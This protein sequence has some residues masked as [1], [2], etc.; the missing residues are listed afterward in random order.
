MKRSKLLI[1]DC[2][3]TVLDTFELIEHIVLSTFYELL[4]DYHISL[5]EAH[6]FFG[7]YINDTFKKYEYLGHS[8]DEYLAVYD[9]YAD[10]YTDKY[11]KAY[12]NIKESFTYLHDN[13][14]ILVIISNKKSFE[15]YRGAR[16][17]GID[18]LIDDV[19][20]AE[21]VKHAKPDPEGIKYIMN[22]Y[23]V[24]SSIIFGD[25]ENDILAGKNAGIYTCGVTWCKTTRNDFLNY[26]ADY[27]IDDPLE[28]INIGENYGK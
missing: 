6:S 16:I 9:K 23:H 27:I 10:L 5:E 20:G 17:C 28:I 7:P 8:V 15:V 21:C 12:K 11:I 4:P 1:F 19:V 13:G 26:N 24:D 14:Y 25:T 22:K 18:N 2:D 3:G